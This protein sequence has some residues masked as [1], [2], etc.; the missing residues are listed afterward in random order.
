VIGDPSPGRTPDPEYR[1]IRDILDRELEW[2]RHALEDLYVLALATWELTGDTRL[3]ADL[4]L[5][6][7]IPGVPT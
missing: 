1:L 5:R 2:S 3:R 4:G 6:E 7:K